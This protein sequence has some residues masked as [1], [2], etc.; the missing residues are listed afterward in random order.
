MISRSEKAVESQEKATEA[1]RPSEAAASR[2]RPR[3]DGELCVVCQD[4]SKTHAFL[5]CGPLAV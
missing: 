5:P 3:D 4:A 1:P 2:K